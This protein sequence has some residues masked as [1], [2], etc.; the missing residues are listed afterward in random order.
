VLLTGG[1]GPTKD[2]IT[3]KVL[4]RYFGAEQLVQHEPTY[5][6]IKAYFEARGRELNPL[7]A[8]MALVPVGATPLENTAGAA[9][10][11]MWETPRG[12]LVVSM[13]GVPHEMKA[14]LTEHVLP[15]ISERF[16]QGV[17]RSQVLRTV[18]IPESSLQKL[19]EDIEDALPAQ[20]KVAYNPG[21]SIL[22]VRLVLQCAT[23]AQPTL[24][25][26]YLHA[27]QRIGE[28]IAAY[29]YADGNTPLEATIGRL[30]RSQGATLST[31]ES[32]TGG[33]LAASIVRVAGSS[34]YF[35]GGV[36]SY[37][38]TAKMH[39]LGVPE[40][41]L[42]EHGA[43]SEAV[44]VALAEGA[45]KQFGTT[46]ALS[47]TGVAGPDGG[48]DTKPVGTVWIA[49]ATPA[50]CTAQRFVFERDRQ[51]NIERAVVT[52]LHQLWKVLH[53]PNIA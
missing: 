22:D 43:V 40:S 34:E 18:G 20:I 38:N 24:E 2:D 44:A 21:L 10:G 27:I 25:P 11:L 33:A 37:S 16:V 3:K 48:S 15:R 32:C 19:I 51:R 12:Q 53:Q 13:P 42:A 49:V 30:L 14:I 5:L 9:P 8:A 52:A 29:H 39:L 6:K 36:A 1:L 35:Q 28:R 7:S 23:D 41:T 46:Y 47:T 45:R 50:G 17:V 4:A 26:L 31:A